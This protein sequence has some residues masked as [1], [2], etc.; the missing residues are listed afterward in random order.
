MEDELCLHD[1]DSYVTEDCLLRKSILVVEFYGL[2]LDVTT[3]IGSEHIRRF[4]SLID[5]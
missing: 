4:K 5:G 3:T 1:S 2:F